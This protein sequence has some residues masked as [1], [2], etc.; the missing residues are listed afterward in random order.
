MLS[1][2]SSVMHAALPE[3]IWLTRHP[4]V[5]SWPL[6]GEHHSSSEKFHSWHL[7]NDIP[8]CT[9]THAHT[10]TR[11][12]TQCQC[13]LITGSLQK[14]DYVHNV[15]QFFLTTKQT[16][17][18]FQLLVHTYMYIHTSYIVP[19][20]HTLSLYV[21]LE[22]D[23]LCTSL[24]ASIS[25]VAMVMPSAPSWSAAGENTSVM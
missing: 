13:V 15:Q 14:H 16:L 2:M 18:I 12:Q 11:T 25:S 7:T 23:L 20:T 8:E 1:V 21:T 10:H 4:H 19:L 6:V 24:A 5:L 3:G 9:H 22:T 17:F